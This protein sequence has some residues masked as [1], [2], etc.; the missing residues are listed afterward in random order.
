MILF[1]PQ[2]LETFD[3]VLQFMGVRLHEMA[4][5]ARTTPVVRDF[6]HII[7]GFVELGGDDSMRLKLVSKS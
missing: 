4:A 1:L 3:G 2:M 6:N 5:G 7:Q